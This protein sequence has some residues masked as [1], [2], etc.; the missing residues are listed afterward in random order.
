MRLTMFQRCAKSIFDLNRLGPYKDLPGQTFVSLY[1]HLV[2]V[3]KIIKLLI[4]FHCHDHQLFLIL[5]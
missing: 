4:I 3:L 5:L 2:K 1:I